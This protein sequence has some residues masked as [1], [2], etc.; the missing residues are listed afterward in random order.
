MSR[1][2][3]WACKC[4]EYDECECPPGCD[5]EVC[6]HDRKMTEKLRK[7]KESEGRQE[8]GRK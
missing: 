8:H 5:C 6:G 2:P 4:G 1:E 3:C 7:R